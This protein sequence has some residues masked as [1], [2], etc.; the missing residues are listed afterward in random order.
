VGYA[1]QIPLEE[2]DVRMD[3]GNLVHFPL[4]D[5]REGIRMGAD[6]AALEPGETLV[7][8]SPR[9]LQK[10]QSYG[11]IRAL[12]WLWLVDGRSLIS[13]PPGAGERVKQIIR[14]VHDPAQLSDERL[15][16]RLRGPVNESLRRAGLGP[17]DRVFSDVCFA[18]NASLLLRHHHGDCRRFTD[19]SIPPAGGLNLPG[20][21]FPD[22]IC[23]AVVVNREAVSIAFSHRPGIMEDRVADIG[24]DTAVGHRRRGYAKTAVSAVAG[25]VIDAG[26]EARYACRPDNVASIAT[27][28]SC[29]FVDYGSSLIL[30]APRRDPKP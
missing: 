7:V 1:H 13:A 19:D 17:V 3:D 8:E 24:I 12:W 25:H 26:G 27:A 2:E 4:I 29:G 5:Q 15:A 28:H 30:S 10:E 18:S 22:G 11:Y 20:H 6:L 23:Y 14:D 21:C 9:R 16:E